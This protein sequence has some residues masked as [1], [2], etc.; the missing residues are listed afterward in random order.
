MTSPPLC[1]DQPLCVSFDY[2]IAKYDVALQVMTLCLGG[3]R[4]HVT[5]YDTR[6]TT[7]HKSNI[8]LEPC[9]GPDTRVSGIYTLCVW[10]RTGKVPGEIKRSRDLRGGRWSWTFKLA[11][12]RS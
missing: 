11:Q 9:A 6:S 3:Q 12:K 7:W 4:G 1:S 5:V 8:T 10:R 2:V